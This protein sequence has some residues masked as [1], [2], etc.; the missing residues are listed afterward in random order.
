[1]TGKKWDVTHAVERYGFNPEQFKW[2]LG[3]FAIKPI[4]E[5]KFL[6]PGDAGY[7]SIDEDEL[8]I[9]TIIDGITRAYPLSVLIR[10]EI[11]D[12]KFDRTHVAVGY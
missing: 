12:E 11:V 2:G 1:M 5:P 6:S 3:P 10:Y 4:L 9:G 7:N 8:I